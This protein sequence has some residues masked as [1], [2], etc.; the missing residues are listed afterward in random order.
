MTEPNSP[1][2]LAPAPARSTAATL[3]GGVGNA[4]LTVAR[5]V[6]T[7]IL[8][9]A[10]IGF[11]A[12]LLA[13]ALSLLLGWLTL[14][15]GAADM[16]RGA[17][18]FVPV[19]L[20]VIGLI[21]FGLHGMQRGIARAAL[22]LEAQWGLVRQVV[23]RV[24]ALLQQQLGT[25]LAN[26]PLATLEDRLKQAIKTYL[27]SEDNDTGRGLLAWVVRKARRLITEKVETF[28][29]RAF[30]AEQGAQG[31]GGIDLEKVRARVAEQL[32]SHLQE[33]VAGPLN[34]QLAVLLLLF[35]GFG[36]GWYHLGLGLLALIR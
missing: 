7:R 21:A 35:F 23:D 10:A 4:A 14:E 31:G 28:L 13:V 17:R 2:P 24:I 5:H 29:L 36:T 22:A 8:L 33:I 19:L 1:P 9:W 30:R 6:P 20:P 32:S 26:L 16:V 18:I 25:R 27:G 12:G 11:C 34:G 3:L 15:G